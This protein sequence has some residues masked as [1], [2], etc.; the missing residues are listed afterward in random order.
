MHLMFFYV[1]HRKVEACA[2]DLKSTSRAELEPMFVIQT[3]SEVD[4][5]DDGYRWRKYG[6]RTVRGNLNPRYV[7][8]FN[9]VAN[10][11]GNLLEET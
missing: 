8:I 6:Q 9:I 1:S 10:G 7:V 5:L 3:I 4:L 11:A 2:T